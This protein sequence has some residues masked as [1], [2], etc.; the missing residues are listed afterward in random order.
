MT[1]LVAFFYALS[2]V[3]TNLTEI[4]PETGVILK[5]IIPEVSSKV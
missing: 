2:A 5:L 3:L 1:P 4:S